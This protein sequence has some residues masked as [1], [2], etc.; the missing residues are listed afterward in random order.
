MIRLFQPRYGPIGI[1]IG[2]RSIKLVQFTA[3]RQDTVDTAR[4]EWQAP[5]FE[6]SDSWSDAV[7]A[8]LRAALAGRGFRGR[9]AVLG[10]NNHQLFIQSI[11]V[12]KSDHG[13][14]MTT[15]EQ[16]VASRIPFPMEETMLDYWESADIR[17]GESL[18]REV[19]VFAC[20]QPV[21]SRLA[22]VAQTA[23]LQPIAID[24]EPA[25]IIRSYCAQF[26]RDD[27]RSQR[28]LLVHLGYRSTAIIICQFDTALF[29]K[30]LE[31][32]GM[33][34]DQCAAQALK[35]SQ[36]DAHALRR[37]LDQA[38]PDVVRTLL[39][40]IRP[41]IE[42]LVREISMCIRY[43]NVT[44]RG[45]GVERMLLGGGEASRHLMEIL[46]S[47]LGVE[48][49]LSDPFRRMQVS[50]ESSHPGLWDVAAGLA[51]RHEERSN[52]REKHQLPAT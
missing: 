51:L 42:K 50:A 2:S 30:Y 1:D 46:A 41:V 10:L 48:A 27:E 6:D 5:P 29:V 20:H 25:A 39:E 26:R 8:A 33:H 7:A 40:A 12:P 11:R 15:V 19:I 49:V 24:V 36:Q 23:G 45:R 22:K 4:W 18:L 9:Q 3:D 35:L 16:E 44:F 28:A 43:H 32:G 31:L 38:E 13:D 47:R 14:L 52:N 17:Q 37:Q 21:A 34:I